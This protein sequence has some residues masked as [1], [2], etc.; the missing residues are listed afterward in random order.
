MGEAQYVEEEL[1]KAREALADAERLADSGGSDDGITNRLYYAA[2]HAAPR[3]EPS[4]ISSASTSFSTAPLR[5]SRAVSSRRSLTF[6]SRRTTATT[7]W[8]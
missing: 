5:E 1:S 6:A 8:T 2:F 7:S 4:A 3:T